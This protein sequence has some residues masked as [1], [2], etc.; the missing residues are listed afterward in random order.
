MMQYSS[1]PDLKY[2]AE[3]PKLPFEWKEGVAPV[4]S[5]RQ[6]ELHYTKHHK[7]YVDKLNTLGKGLE[8]KTIESI[9]VELNGKPDQKV[10]F[11]QAAQH[12]NHTFYWHCLTPNGKA[13]PKTLEEAITKD[14]GSVEKFKEA[15][16][17]SGANNFGSGWTW[18]CVDP[19]SGKLVLHNT[20]NAGCPLTEGLRPIFTADVWEHAY[21]KDFENR[22]P[23]YLK[24]LWKVVNWEYVAQQLTNAKK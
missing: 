21:Y 12:F 15:F 1:L 8:G 14:F 6:L 2:P 7:A 18:L 20:S 24:E 13:M 4:F 16:Q 22:R 5:A 17:T 19:K 9:L 11:N 10:A 3:L 23:D